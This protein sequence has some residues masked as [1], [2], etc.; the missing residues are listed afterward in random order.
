MRVACPYLRFVAIVSSVGTLGKDHHQRRST[1]AP[2][3]RVLVVQED[4]EDA[5]RAI[6]TVESI[7]GSMEAEAT[8]SGSRALHLLEK[9][10]FDCLVLAFDLPDLDGLEV[11][12]QLRETDEKT[13]VIVWTDRDAP[14][15]EDALLEAGADAYLTKDDQDAD[16]IEEAL[17][18]Y[19]QPLAG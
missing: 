10:R 16:R 12:R 6:E 19:A 11:V 18:R 4:I 5:K 17:R 7:S 3:N 8:P 13:P 9:D 14:P 2:S 15:L 1:G